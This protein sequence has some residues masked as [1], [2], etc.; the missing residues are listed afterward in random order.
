MALPSNATGHVEW[1]IAVVAVLTRLFA[2]LMFVA[3]LLDAPR[4]WPLLGIFCVA[5]AESLAFA[6]LC[7]RRRR[8]PAWAALVDMLAVAAT[9]WPATILLGEPSP[10]YNYLMVAVPVAGLAPWSLPAAVGVGATTATAA[11][12]NLADAG[13]GDVPDLLNPVGITLIAWLMATSLRVTAT[14]LD[15]RWRR[16]AQVAAA[17]A[18]E[19]ERVRRSVALRGRLLSVL[20]W[21]SSTNVVADERVRGWLHEETEW[22]RRFVTTGTG[23]WAAGL[24]TGLRKVVAEKESTGL[25]VNV[26]WPVDEP[27]LRPDRVQALSG[28]VREALTNITKHAGATAAHLVVH[29]TSD[30]VVVEISD[31]GRGFDPATTPPREGT[32]LS[33][34]QRVTD[35][36]GQA[37]IDSAPGRGTRVR[38]RM[39]S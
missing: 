7:L 17:L 12:A 4:S 14:R 32:R 27:P 30:E 15:E 31:E 33:I 34:R 29:K 16:A 10:T 8:I 38:L 1:G 20:E 18:A 25:R 22:L 2:P 24:L 21:L 28:A 19:R 5:T 6:L 35:A 26:T 23:E 9:L 13:W 39:P 11:T 37:E 36:G 3:P